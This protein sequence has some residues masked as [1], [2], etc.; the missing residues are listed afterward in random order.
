MLFTQHVDPQVHLVLLAEV[1]SRF[2]VGAF[3]ASIDRTRKSTARCVFVK[4]VNFM[5]IQKQ[6]VKRHY[7]TNTGITVKT[8]QLWP[9]WHIATLVAASGVKIRQLWRRVPSLVWS[10]QVQPLRT[11]TN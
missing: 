1:A 10:V 8:V 3:S 2:L 5:V 4:R 11:L 9:S 6:C 7:S